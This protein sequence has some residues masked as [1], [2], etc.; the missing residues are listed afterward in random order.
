MSNQKDSQ[1][2]K[3]YHHGDLRHAL[4]QAGLELLTEGGAASLD[5]RKVAR[6]VGVSHSASYHHFPDK[7]SLIA[8]INEEGFHHLAQ[9][10]QD[11]VSNVSD[12]PFEQL[13]GIARAYLLFAQENSWL[14]REM[15][16]GLTI[17]REAFS[18][19]YAASKAVFKLYVEVVKRGQEKGKIIDGDPG[20][21]A[22][23]LWSL[24][25]GVAMLMI[26]HQMRPYADGPEGVE[27]MARLCMQTL[28]NGLGRE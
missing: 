1:K 17:K 24:L 23:V 21:L 20:E 27:R 8:A 18:G 10:I 14:M 3:P 13:Q 25:H 7:Q 11:A 4:I 5:L 12:S 22:S 15:F 2:P 16:S 9:A 26:E 28:Y 6:K 19:L